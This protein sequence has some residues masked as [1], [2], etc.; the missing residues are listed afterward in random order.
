[1]PPVKGSR[2]Q[3]LWRDSLVVQR[4]GV[5][6]FKKPRMRQLKITD[7]KTFTTDG[8]LNVMMRKLEIRPK[9]REEPAI[10]KWRQLTLEQCPRFLV[11]RKVQ[12]NDDRKLTINP[13]AAL[14]PP[15]SLGVGSLGVRSGRSCST[16]CESTVPQTVSLEW[17]PD[18][19]LATNDG[20]I[21]RVEPLNADVFFAPDI[22]RSGLIN[23]VFGPSPTRFHETNQPINSVPTNVNSDWELT[24]DGFL[25]PESITSFPS[26]TI[27]GDFPDLSQIMTEGF[28]CMQ[29][30]PES[31]FVRNR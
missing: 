12:R 15:S 5:E 26:P 10:K 6:K 13:Q 8:G 23:D 25:F 1:M 31:M 29:T 22:E 27:G 18:G 4:G 11:Q 21:D 9:V 16:S 17:N 7:C 2:G 24:Y 14:I 3:R 28:D 19:F 30:E 20:V